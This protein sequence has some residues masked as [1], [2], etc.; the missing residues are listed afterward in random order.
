MTARHDQHD[1]RQRQLAVLQHERLDV[2]REVMDRHE[3]EAGGGRRGLRKG[4]A[5]EQRTHE[6]GALRHRDRSQVAPRGL[7]L[8]EAPLD[9]AADVPDVLPRRQLRHHAAPLAMNRH[10]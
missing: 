2:A 6:A 3:R 7:G 9:D 1:G 4:D 8:L 5:N 10:L